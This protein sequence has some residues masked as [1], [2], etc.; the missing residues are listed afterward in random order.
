MIAFLIDQLT[1]INGKFTHLRKPEAEPARTR[2]KEGGI[3]PGG[4]RYAMLTKELS[5][6]VLRNWFIP[7]VFPV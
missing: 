5:R 2:K 1:R 7:A 6:P 4:L 3:I